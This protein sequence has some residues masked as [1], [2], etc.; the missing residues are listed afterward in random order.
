MSRVESKELPWQSSSPVLAGLLAL[1]MA[2]G[3]HFFYE[4][5]SKLLAT[6]WT[7]T[8]PRPGLDSLG[9]KRLKTCASSTAIP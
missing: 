4:G 2:I 5:L 9:A 1:R 8:Q 3:W 6:G 7:S